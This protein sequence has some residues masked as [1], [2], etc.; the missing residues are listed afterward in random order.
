MLVLAL[1]W[2]TTAA[3]VGPTG[4]VL[5]APAAAA[6]GLAAEADLAAAATGPAAGLAG[7]AVALVLPVGGADAAG[8]AVLAAANLPIHTLKK[9]CQAVILNGKSRRVRTYKRTQM[10]GSYLRTLRTVCDNTAR[11]SNM[12]LIVGLNFT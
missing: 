9:K 7:G 12:V 5:A 10:S 6:A 3:A 1:T 2:A 8:A 11:A 4:V